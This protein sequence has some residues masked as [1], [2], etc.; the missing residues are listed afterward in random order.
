MTPQPRAR[1]E[2]GEYTSNWTPSA[3]GP[4]SLDAENEMWI[5]EVRVRTSQ[6]LEIQ[7]GPRYHSRRS[8]EVQTTSTSQHQ[9]F[10]LP[11]QQR[12]EGEDEMP[13]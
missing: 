4:Y 6:E 5:E 9:V 2:G 1:Q 11:P 10:T 8:G 7:D 3:E 13:S 12:E